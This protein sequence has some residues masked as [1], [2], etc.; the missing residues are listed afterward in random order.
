MIAAKN[1]IKRNIFNSIQTYTQQEGLARY[2]SVYEKKV[3]FTEASY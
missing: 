3:V 1:S 2:A